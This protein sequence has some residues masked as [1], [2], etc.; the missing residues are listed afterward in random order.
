AAL[1]VEHE[2][3]RCRQFVAVA[4]AV[5]GA[6]LAGLGV[7]AL[8]RP[9]LVVGRRAGRQEARR[10][11]VDG[12]AVVA[13]IERA[14]RAGGDAVGPPPALPISLLLP[15][16]ATRV[17]FLPEISPRITEPSAIHTGPSGKPRPLARMRISGMA[18]SPVQELTWRMIAAQRSSRGR[19]ASA[20]SAGSIATQR[21]TPMSR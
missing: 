13:D 12:A 1:P 3:V 17:T 5:E 2:V 14:V 20:P 19:V 9:A 15:S 16:G 6:G 21:S 8:D 4:L 18:P 11:L 7:D 10:R